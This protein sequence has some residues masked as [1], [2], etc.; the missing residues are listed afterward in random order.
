MDVIGKGGGSP[1]PA[2]VR[3]RMESGLGADFGDVRIH[4]DAAAASSAQAVQAKAYTVGNEVVFNTGSY[5]PDTQEG[6]HTLAHELSHVVQ[7]RSGAVDGTDTGEGIALSHPQDRFE[8]A[9]EAAADAFGRN[10]DG[11]GT[12]SPVGSVQRQGDDDARTAPMMPLQRD[13]LEEEEEPTAQP[14]ALQR[15]EMAP[16]EEQEES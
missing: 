1:L 16:E 13:E 14:L 3:G 15:E 5:S 7:Q 6:Q 10:A 8:Q 2:G 4:D 12:P 11:G 9:A